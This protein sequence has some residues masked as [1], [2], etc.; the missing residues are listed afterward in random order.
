M[1]VTPS[2]FLLSLKR[3]S[4][5]PYEELS[6]FFQEAPKVRTKGN[7]YRSPKRASEQFSNDFYRAPPLFIILSINSGLC[8]FLEN[9]QKIDLPGTF[10]S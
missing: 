2:P 1:R 5:H 7:D 4:G 6:H 10:F 9:L 3:I 8:M